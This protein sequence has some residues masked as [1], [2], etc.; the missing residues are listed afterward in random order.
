MFTSEF[1]LLDSNF[2]EG[3]TEN[4]IEDILI[5]RM[6]WVEEDNILTRWIRNYFSDYP[7]LDTENQINDKSFEFIKKMMQKELITCSDKDDNIV[8]LDEILAQKAKIYEL[9]QPDCD[10]T[11]QYTFTFNKSNKGHKFAENTVKKYSLI[12]NVN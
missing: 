11:T 4:Q 8:N 12:K 10:L 7:G 5:A 1:A 3:M 9:M 2:F 6:L